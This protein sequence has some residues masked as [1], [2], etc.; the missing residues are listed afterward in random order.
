MLTT[1]FF[2]VEY[3]FVV[4]IFLYFLIVPLSLFCKPALQ[5]FVILLL[6]SGPGNGLGAALSNLGGN[7]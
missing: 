7:C 5:L 3:F 4:E 2:A 6:K 1:G